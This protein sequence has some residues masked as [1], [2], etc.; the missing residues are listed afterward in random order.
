MSNAIR[1]LQ[2]VTMK[3]SIEDKAAAREDTQAAIAD[4][5]EAIGEIHKQR[6]KKAEEEAQA[7]RDE[8]GGRFWG[9]IFGGLIGLLVG[10]GIGSAMS[11]D[12]DDAAAGAGKKA[13][14]ADL[15]RAEG[16]DAMEDALESA[17][18]AENFES[19]VDKFVGEIRANERELDELTA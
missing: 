2:T 16:A 13:G 6:T 8:F 18:N 3:Q 1:T 19:Q 10:W 4:Q 12:N 7:I 17:D 15:D 11:N 5:K 14:L 9:F